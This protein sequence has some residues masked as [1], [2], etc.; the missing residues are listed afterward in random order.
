MI[1]NEKRGNEQERRKMIIPAQ[2][3]THSGGYQQRVHRGCC[4][5][6]SH[7]EDDDERAGSQVVV[8]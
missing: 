6:S 4:S 3:H 2:V 1:S 7:D 5:S 8:G